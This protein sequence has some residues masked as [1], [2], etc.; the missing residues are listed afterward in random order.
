MAL[1]LLCDILYATMDEFSRELRIH[2]YVTNVTDNDGA[3]QKESK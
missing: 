1:T 2:C 3:S